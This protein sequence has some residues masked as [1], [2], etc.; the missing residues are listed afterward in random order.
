MT[1][2][3]LVIFASGLIAISVVLTAVLHSIPFLIFV[4]FEE[5]N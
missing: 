5:F 3:E 2:F 4:F 1:P